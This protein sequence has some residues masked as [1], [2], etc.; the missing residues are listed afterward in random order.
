MTLADWALRPART[1]SATPKWQRDAADLVGPPVYALVR[2]WFGPRQPLVLPLWMVP[3]IE[4]K[5]AT[6]D[7]YWLDILDRI[8]V[9]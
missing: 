8:E 9:Q 3:H 7:P 4:E 2:D 5:A 6:G 1:P